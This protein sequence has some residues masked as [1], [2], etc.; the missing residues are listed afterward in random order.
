V[1]DQLPPKP[2]ETPEPQGKLAPSED[3][4]ALETQLSRIR[5][6][7]SRTSDPARLIALTKAEDLLLARRDRLA[8]AGA[9]AAPE[10]AEP[11]RV[12]MSVER[13]SEA[14]PN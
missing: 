7:Y 10:A 12:R 11:Q 9:G 8:G 6:L 4:W 3:V 2:I 1:S 13:A 14:Q 5:G